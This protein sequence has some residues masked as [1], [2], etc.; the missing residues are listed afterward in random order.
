MNIH[1]LYDLAILCIIQRRP[2]RVPTLIKNEGMGI[3]NVCRG[4][5]SYQVPQA[6]DTLTASVRSC[7][8]DHRGSIEVHKVGKIP[9]LTGRADAGQWGT[10]TINTACEGLAPITDA[11]S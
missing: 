8:M 7:R 3:L 9:S 2:D 10:S 5:G 6:D 4:L 1:N 11:N